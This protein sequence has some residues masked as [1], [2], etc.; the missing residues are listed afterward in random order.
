VYQPV[1][2]A[3]EYVEFAVDRAAAAAVAVAVVAAAAA[4][5]VVVVETGAG[6]VPVDSVGLPSD[7]EEQAGF[8]AWLACFEHSSA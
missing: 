7:F 4:A 8:V 1:T 5:A 2:I 6:P 3:E